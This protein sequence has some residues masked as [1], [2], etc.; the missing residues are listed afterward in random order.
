MAEQD[1]HDRPRLEGEVNVRLHVNGALTEIAAQPDDRLLDVLREELGLTGA[2]LGC[3][4]GACGACTVLLDGEPARACL[5]GV[6]KVGSR[7][8]TTVEGLASA[9]ELHP[10]QRAFLEVGAM[11]CGFCTPGMVLGTTALLAGGGVPTR[12]EAKAALAGH[13]CRCGAYS[14]ILEAVQRA[15][16]LSSELGAPTP[17]ADPGLESPPELTGRPAVPWDLVPPEK[18]DYFEV[19]SEGLVVVLRP[20]SSGWMAG[21]GAWL[22]LSPDGTV[23]AFSG[24]V[25]VGQDSATA[26][27]LLVA[28]ELRV[29]LRSVRMVLGDTDLCPFDPG[30]FGSRSMPGAGEDLRAAA[31]AAREVLSSIGAAGAEGAARLRGLRR[32]EIVADPP[33]PTPAGRWTI[34]GRPTIRAAARDM[35]TGH[36]RYP[37]DLTRPGMLQGRVLRPPALGA[38]LVSVDLAAARAVPGVV[39]VHEGDV[40]AAAAARVETAERALAAIVARWD[41]ELQPGERSLVEDIR[42]NLVD[43]EGWMGPAEHGTGDVEAALGE[44]AVTLAETYTT[45]Y[46]AHAP[47][48]T[49][50]VLAEW[51]EGRLTVWAGTQ[52]PFNVRR[53]LAETLGLEESRIRVVVPVTGGGF[54]GKHAFRPA[55]EAAVVARAAG[56]PVKIAWSREEEFRWGYF[57]PAAVID[58]RSGASGDGSLVAWDFENLNAGSP[59]ML[60]PYSVPN[61]RIRYQPTVSPLPQGSYRALAATAN[62]FARESHMDELAHRLDLDPLEFRLA[63]LED[64]RLAAV[65]RAAAGA[66]GWAGRARGGGRGMGIAAGVEKGGRVA[67]CVEVRV[68]TGGRLQLRRVVTAYECGAIVNPE[69]VRNQVQ[70]AAVM[71]LGG[72]L[73]EAVHYDAGRVL[74]PAFS[75]YRVPRFTDLPEIEVLLLDRR[76]LPP[77]GA[78]E[79]PVIA[80]APAL[81]NAVFEAT[82]RRIRSLPLAAGGALQV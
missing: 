57:R 28:E 11:Q 30:T 20:S 75:S 65:L 68:E 40:V 71:A 63:C 2:K 81:A 21:G 22:H 29:P 60:T 14:R 42:S 69:T 38:R 48:E 8:V 58:V 33:R 26:L 34:A 46:V 82:G 5:V 43:A 7:A 24:K 47:M 72:A 61:Q 74:N 51:A 1:R 4:E 12:E 55:L 73:F 80:V 54:G 50:A 10:V 15:A 19:L 66:S 9:G 31:A 3:G 76:D 45:A 64:D 6:G 59:G 17:P 39:V 32:V 35:V 79:T 49:R 70:G 44:A 16:E 77:A 25:D 62:A 67:T 13:L 27:A 53:Q 78:G 41:A 56:R 23:T 36:L 52:T 37:S 18:R